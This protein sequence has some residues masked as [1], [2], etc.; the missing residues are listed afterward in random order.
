M[1]RKGWLTLSAILLGLPWL[2]LCIAGIGWL[3]QTGYSLEAL[4]VFALFY[5]GGWLSIRQLRNRSLL[6]LPSIQPDQHWPPAA[7]AAWRKVNDLAERLDSQSYPLTDSVRII[8]LVKRVMTEVAYHFAPES[9]RAELDVPLRNL[10]FI[11]ERVCCDMRELL[12]DKVP[13]SHLLTVGDGLELWKWKERIESGHWVYRIGKL[14]I[15]PVSSIPDEL[16]RFLAGKT[17]AYPTGLLERWLLQTLIKKIGYY[18]IQLYSG[19][20]I[21]LPSESPQPAPENKKSAKQ[22]LDILVA[23]QLKAGKSSLVNAL[24]GELRAPTDVLPLT[25]ELSVYRIRNEDIGDVMICDSPGYGDLERWFEKDPD[26]AFGHFDLILLVCSATQAGFDADATFLNAFRGWFDARLERRR[27]PLLI[28]VSHIDRL[29]P[30]R[31]WQPPYDVAMPRNQKERA[32][33]G[34]L[35]YIGEALAVPLEDCI[36]VCL[37]EHRTYNVE[38]VWSAVAGKLPESLRAQYL[39]C[40]VNAQEKEKWALLKKQLA[41]AGRYVVDRTQHIGR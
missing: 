25:D 23:G 39:R 8:E 35:E 18:A 13:F 5:S 15:S 1:R 38:A 29:R 2:G 21:L 41:S 17:A 32:I 19:Q 3:W 27:P 31:E 11:A 24:F 37:K 28:I 34:V 10:L 36:P 4:A 14:L 40:L 16:K 33:R 26:R 9:K 7:E 20:T 12:D 30:I 22:P 6:S